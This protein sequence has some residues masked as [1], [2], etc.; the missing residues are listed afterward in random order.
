V[1][2]GLGQTT[3]TGT[4]TLIV[5]TDEITETG[6][7]EVVDGVRMVF[8]LAPGTEAPVD[9]HIYLPDFKALCAA[10]NA[11]HTLHNLLTLRGALVRD[12]HAWSRYLTEAI[13]LFGGEAEVV[14]ASHHW[15][16]W[17]NER[18]M[19]F[20]TIQRDLYAYVHDQT[21]RLL[22]QGLVGAEIADQIEL[23]PVLVNA[24]ST[25]GYYGSVSH[26]VKAIYQRYLG[27]FDGN[28]AHLWQHPPAE[29]ARRYVEYMG[30]AD[31]VVDKARAS[32]DAGDFRWVAE[33]VGHVV[34]AEP[35]HAAARDLLANTYEQ[36]GYGSENGT[37]R[38]W[39]LSGTT[40]L[41]E[42]AFGTPTVTASADVIAQLTPQMLFDGLSFIVVPARAIV[43][44][45]LTLGW[46]TGGSQSNVKHAG[47]RSWAIACSSQCDRPRGDQ[48]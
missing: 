23:P 38:S 16:T 5:P 10:E 48:P 9:M 40:E 39:Y 7:T 41:R 31:A 13:D 8:Q 18:V 12:P 45:R 11:T 36:L 25:H 15:R 21:L 43:R 2:A 33:V 42:G 29:A 27:W 19:E 47:T 22:N 6:E 34:F 28:P 17:G 3:S 20:L 1:G 4:I 24:W 37:W 30:G 44:A 26:D 35:D 32:F 14:F 46:S